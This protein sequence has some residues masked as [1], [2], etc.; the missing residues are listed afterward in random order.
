MLHPALVADDLKAGLGSG[1]NATIDH[2]LRSQAPGGAI[3]AENRIFWNE[4]LNRHHKLM[5][6]GKTGIV[7][8]LGTLVVV[9]PLALTLNLTA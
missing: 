5:A 9:L 4:H 8:N 6:A 3:F 1:I 7:G 2:R